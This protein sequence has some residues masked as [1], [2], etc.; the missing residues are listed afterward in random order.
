MFQVSG[1]KVFI[2]GSALVRLLYS[3]NREERFIWLCT[4]FSPV[5]NNFRAVAFRVGNHLMLSTWLE[6]SI[7]PG[8]VIQGA[9]SSPVY[10]CLWRACKLT[11]VWASNRRTC[12]ALGP[13]FLAHYPLG[14]E[15]SCLSSVVA[16][17]HSYCTLPV[18]HLSLLLYNRDRMK[19]R[20]LASKTI[21]VWV[22]SYILEYRSG[23]CGACFTFVFAKFPTEA[24]KENKW[25]Q[26]Q[27]TATWAMRPT[28]VHP[29][30]C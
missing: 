11:I 3:H 19:R 17:P 16:S 2:C 9:R 5:W 7:D 23:S 29:R 10:N 4:T 30:R 12:L 1:N 21:L 20:S 13:A 22:L 26:K 6:K 8:R 27:A 15:R 25:K 24:L 18:S 28:M 14:I